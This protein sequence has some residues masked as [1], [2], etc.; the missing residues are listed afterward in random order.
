MKRVLVTGATGFVGRYAV[1]SLLERGYEVHAVSSKP[2][3][4]SAA[5]GGAR[6]HAA[7][8]LRDEE[9][10][11]LVGRISPTHLLHFAWYAEPGKYWTS[12]E[13]FRWVRASLNL[14]EAF[15]AGGGRRVVMAGTCAEYEWG[16]DRICSEETTPLAPSTPY[17]TCKHSLHM[18]LEAFAAQAGLSAAWGRIFFLY[19]PR[20][21]PSRLVASVVNSLLRN[22]VARCSH[23]NQVRDFLHV[24]DVA[25]AFVT[26]LDG[27]TAGAVN[28][29]SGVPV[30]LKEV[31]HTIA[32]KLG[33]EELIQLDAVPAPANEPP[34][35]VADVRRL[36]NEVGWSPKYDLS[37]GLDDTI[38]WWRQSLKAGEN[39]AGQ[40]GA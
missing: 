40:G 33:R 25:R 5:A 15:A 30:T 18:M 26:L 11:S 13:N 27:E 12:T 7:D 34:L 14:L 10:A 1:A 20:E 3:E 38:E 32:R 23:G 35:L 24:E 21:Y 6:W 19:G 9:V 17:G 36:K 39:R 16:G 28:I 29:A 8:L 2:R 22:E 4:E 31:I 37:A